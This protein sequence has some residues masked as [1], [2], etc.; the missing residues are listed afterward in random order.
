M[1]KIAIHSHLFLLGRKENLRFI[2]IFFRWVGNRRCI[3][4]LGAKPLETSG[5]ATSTKKNSAAW[6]HPALVTLNLATVAVVHICATATDTAA[7]EK[8][9]RLGET[10]KTSLALEKPK[11]SCVTS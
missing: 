9:E 1:R 7:G 5:E 3:T 4:P 8:N 2:R 11:M 10:A 6:H